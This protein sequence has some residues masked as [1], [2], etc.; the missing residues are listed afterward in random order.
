LQCLPTFFNYSFYDFTAFTTTLPLNLPIFLHFSGTHFYLLR[1]YS[2]Y[3][4]LSTIFTSYFTFLMYL[5]RTFFN[6]TAFNTTF[7]HYFYQFFLLSFTLFLISLFVVPLAF[8]LSHV[9]FP[10]SLY[11]LHNSFYYLLS[12]TF[13]SFPIYFA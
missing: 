9:S 12:F 13:Y 10:P 8:M 5:L 11:I 2:L 1:F 6:F 4:Y 3:R 7:F